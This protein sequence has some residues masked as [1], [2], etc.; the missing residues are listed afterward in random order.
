MKRWSSLRRTAAPIPVALMAVSS[1]GQRRAAT[2]LGGSFPGARLMA[3]G[4]SAGRD[5]LH[6]VVVTRATAE[7]AFELVPDRLIV[8]LVTHAV[9]D[10]DRRH[11]HARG[12]IAA[13]QAMILAERL[14]H[15]MQ[16]PVL[17][18]QT[19]DGGDLGAIE[20]PGEDRAGFD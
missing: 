7:I 4:A 10:V 19:L 16:R 20:L 6:D 15:G 11:D 14:L 12:A 8:E 5:G 18:R 17:R 3:H 9:H 2:L 1:C 13:L